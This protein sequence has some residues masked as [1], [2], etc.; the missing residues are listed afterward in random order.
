MTDQE[1]NIAIAE[2]CGWIKCRLAIKGAGGGIRQPTAYGF[3][4]KRNYEAP[5]PDYLKDLNAMHEAVLAMPQD[6]QDRFTIELTRHCGSHKLAVNASA[7]Q[8]AE[9]FLRTLRKWKE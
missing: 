4:P 6:W 3:P 8:R 7:R 2:A 9:V 5:C 1:I